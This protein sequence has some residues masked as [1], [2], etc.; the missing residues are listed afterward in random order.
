METLA[1]H[2]ERY[3]IH[4]GELTAGSYRLK[5]LADGTTVPLVPSATL[6]ESDG[7]PGSVSVLV[8]ADRQVDG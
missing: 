2:A 5:R 8:V 6:E 3:F 7:V 1:R 4:R